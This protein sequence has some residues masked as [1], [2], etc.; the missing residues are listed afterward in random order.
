MTLKGFISIEA[1]L[2]TYSLTFGFLVYVHIDICMN[3]FVAVSQNCVAFCT[4]ADNYLIFWLAGK[5][6][7]VYLAVG[8]REQATETITQCRWCTAKN[9]SCSTLR[10]KSSTSLL[11]VI[12]T[13]V[14]ASPSPWVTLQV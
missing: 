6:R 12:P 2:R 4:S 10:R 14:A 7:C 3:Y 13:G 8:C 1:P 9:T 5:K 11:S